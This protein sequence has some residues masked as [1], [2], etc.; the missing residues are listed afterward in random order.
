MAQS[1]SP[2]FDHERDCEPWEFVD[3][4][5]APT[6]A[7]DFRCMWDAEPM[8]AADLRYRRREAINK[9]RMTVFADL[10]RRGEA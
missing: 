4:V 3:A 8:S 6:D 10:L 1:R 2:W 9:H 5:P 7:V